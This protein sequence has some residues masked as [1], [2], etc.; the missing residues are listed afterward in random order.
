M[1]TIFRDSEFM[2]FNAGRVKLAPMVLQHTLQAPNERPDSLQLF[3]CRVEVWQLGVAVQVLREM[4]SDQRPQDSIWSHAA[5]GLIA[6]AFSYFEMIGK[7]LNPGSAK[8]KTAR[9]DFNYGL[10]DVYP[11]HAPSSG[12]YDDSDVPFVSAFR[13]RVRNG[14]YHLAYTKNNLIIHHN[15]GVSEKDLDFKPEW[16]GARDVY[17]LDPHLMVRTI[18]DHFSGFVRRLREPGER[19]RLMQLKFDE[20]FDEFHK[21]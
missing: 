3:E 4:E 7:S 1:T 6:I 21:P 18:V 5:Y 11:E 14:M 17:F 10:C 9:I 20:F 16:H 13:D 19:Y 12:K 8:S 15:R 2:D